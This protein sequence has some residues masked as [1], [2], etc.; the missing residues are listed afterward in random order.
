MLTAGRPIGVTRNS[1]LP[2]TSAFTTPADDSSTS[3]L[4]NLSS[5]NDDYILRNW[6]AFTRNKFGDQ[7]AVKLAEQREHLRNIREDEM[8]N[9]IWREVQTKGA[10][11]KD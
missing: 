7:A 1:T 11:R 3:A 9:T 4:D 6:E 8:L 10:G 2:R 5:S